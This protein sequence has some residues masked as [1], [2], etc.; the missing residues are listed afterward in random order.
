MNPKQIM[1]FEEVVEFFSATDEFIVQKHDKLHLRL[2]LID[3]LKKCSLLMYLPTINIQQLIRHI[4]QLQ[5]NMDH[6]NFDK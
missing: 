3:N 6:Q 5:W 1:T 2:I 4:T